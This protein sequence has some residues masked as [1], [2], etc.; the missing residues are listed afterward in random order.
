MTAYLKDQTENRWHNVSKINMTV[1][2]W[3]KFTDQDTGNNCLEEPGARRESSDLEMKAARIPHNTT[4]H[5]PSHT[6]P[7]PRQ[8]HIIKSKDQ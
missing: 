4:P 1:K 2:Q 7:H 5:S 3:H 6:S 8:M